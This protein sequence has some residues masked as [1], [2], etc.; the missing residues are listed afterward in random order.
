MLNI[1]LLDAIALV[2]IALRL[3]R[4]GRKNLGESLHSLITISLLAALLLGFRVA[5]QL[6]GALSS[7]ADFMSAVPGLGSKLLIILLAWYLIHI[8]RKKIAYWLEAALP[9]STHETITFISEL[10]RTLILIILIAWLTEN[11]FGPQQDAPLIVQW[12]R[13]GDDWLLNRSF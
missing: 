10:L 9:K 4:A 8:L 11:W 5:S 12:V 1:S 3:L 13:M 6:R 7:M 2:F